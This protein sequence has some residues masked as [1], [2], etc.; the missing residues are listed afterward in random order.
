MQIHD[1]TLRFITWFDGTD[2]EI[3][4]GLTLDIVA[5]LYPIAIIII[6]FDK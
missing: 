4:N 2:A 6:L 5:L 1:H 3:C